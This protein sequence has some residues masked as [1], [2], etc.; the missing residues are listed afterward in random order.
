[1]TITCL[2]KEGRAD[3]GTVLF[4]L[5]ILGGQALALLLNGGFLA[6]Q[7]SL[8]LGLRLLQPP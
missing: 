3:L 7:C 2:W 5:L 4:K 8:L 1:M 6:R